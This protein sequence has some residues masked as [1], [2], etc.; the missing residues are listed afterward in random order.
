MDG[1]GHHDTTTSRPMNSAIGYPFNGVL[2]IK[3]DATS[4]LQVI[5]Y[6]SMN[7]RR[8]LT[9]AAQAGHNH[10]YISGLLPVKYFI[11]SA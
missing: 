4:P 8:E 10:T 1:H 2:L 5:A 9:C 6:E 11:N 7:S 3:K